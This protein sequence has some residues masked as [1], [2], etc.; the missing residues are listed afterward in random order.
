MPLQGVNLV[1]HECEASNTSPLLSTSSCARR[2]SR[3]N[4]DGAISQQ[5]AASAA[6][7]EERDAEQPQPPT[8][9]ESEPAAACA[10]LALLERAKI[11][12]IGSGERPVASGMPPVASTATVGFVLDVNEAICELWAAHAEDIERCCAPWMPHVE[13]ALTRGRWRRL[14]ISTG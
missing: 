10:R 5:T 9:G 14:C 13:A 7:F 12:L 6:A 1:D 8:D 3:I 2:S 4:D 11:M